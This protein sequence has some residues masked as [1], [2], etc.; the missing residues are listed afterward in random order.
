M[1]AWLWSGFGLVAA[2]APNDPYDP[3][4]PYS[5]EL[6]PHTNSKNSKNDDPY[7]PND[8]IS[9]ISPMQNISLGD[10]LENGSLGSYGSSSEEGTPTAAP[11][12]P[13]SGLPVRP[14]PYD[15]TGWRTYTRAL[16]RVRGTAK[17]LSLSVESMGISEL[18][19][20]CATLD[21][22]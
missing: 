6:S 15:S 7:D 11:T 4:D 20:L 8:P 2:D 12:G 16:L 9:D 17:E 19:A 22:R 1:R 5:G 21:S 3:N 13:L 18:M 10:S 14:S